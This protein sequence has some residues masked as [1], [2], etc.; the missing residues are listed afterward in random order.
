MSGDVIKAVR[1]LPLGVWVLLAI[2]AAGLAGVVIWHPE[3]VPEPYPNTRGWIIL[4]A[5]ILLP[6]VLLWG[7]WRILQAIAGA[8]RTPEWVKVNRLKKRYAQLFD[9]QRDLLDKTYKTGKDN[10]EVSLETSEL[11]I[12][13]QLEDE[14]F[15]H[16]HPAYVYYANMPVNCSLTPECSKALRQIHN[17]A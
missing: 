8:I 1:E 13:K 6:L 5:F 4:A 3:W 11:R 17:L 7:T 9:T 2:V 14:G 10:F 12:F 15:I 16:V